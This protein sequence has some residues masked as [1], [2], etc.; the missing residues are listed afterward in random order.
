MP[1][2]SP[3]TALMAIKVSMLGA[4][5][6]AKTPMESNDSPANATGRLP[7]E[8]DMGPTATTETPHA[9]NVTVGP[10][11]LPRPPRKCRTQ[12]R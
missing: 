2:P 1:P 10:S 11:C 8:S 5:A 3:V 12:W 7:K 6:D 4:K 9:A